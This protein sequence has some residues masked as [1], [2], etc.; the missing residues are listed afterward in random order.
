MKYLFKPIAYLLIVCLTHNSIAVFYISVGLFFFNPP[1]VFADDFLDKALQGQNL[2]QSLL[3]EFSVPNVNPGTGTITLQNGS[4]AGQT[5]EQNQLFQ[6]I[7]PGSLDSAAASYG[8]A[9]AMGTVVNDSTNNLAAGSST[10]AK[11]YQTLLGANTSIPNIYNDPI[12][13]TSDNVLSLTSPIIT[14]LFSGCEKTTNFSEK[15][16]NFHIDDLKTCKKTLK[17]ESCKVDRIIQE[18]T[19]NDKV[20]NKISSTTNDPHPNTE[21]VFIDSPSIIEMQLGVPW[22][23][24]TG[25]GGCYFW[26]YTMVLHVNDPSRLIKATI[27]SVTADGGVDITIDGTRI[28]SNGGGSCI[29]DAWALTPKKDILPY[30][31][32][33]DH[34]ITVRVS[35]DEND[36]PTVPDGGAHFTFRKKP[37]IKETFIDFPPGCRERIFNSWPPTYTPPAFTPDGSL[38]DAASTDYWKC[39]DADDSRVIETI[40]I[41]P[42]E[43]G[44]Y[45]EPILPDPPTSP[46]APICYSAETRVPGHI[47]LPCFTDM[48]GDE[49]CPEY[50][51]NL[52][53]HDTCQELQDNPQCSYI[54]EKCVDGGVSP[55]TGV[56]QQFIVTYDCGTDYEAACDQTNTGE[57]TICDAPIKCMG[58][59]CVNQAT[60]SNPDFIEAATALQTLNE[61]QKDNGCSEDSATCKLFAGQSYEC[62]MA[63]L[64]VLGSVDCCN[65]PIQG[66]WMDFIELGY[67]SW[68]AIDSSVQLY[69]MDTYGVTTGAW[70]LVTDGTVLSTPVGVLADTYNAV[71]STFTSAL[72]SVTSMLGEEIGTNLGI[73]A[74]KQQMVQ[75]LG[76]WIASTFGETAASTLLTAT[77]SGAGAAAT[78]T[79]SMAGSMLSSIVTVVGIIYA[80]YQIA[81]MVVQLVFACTEDEVQLNMLKTQGLCTKPTAIG[82]YCSADT[83]FGCVATKQVYCC[84]SSPFARIFNEQARPQ[85]GLTFGDPKTPNCEGFTPEQI[86]KLD[87]KKMDFSEWLNMLKATDHLARNAATADILYTIENRTVG[88][89]PN[90]QNEN[91]IQRLQRQTNGTNIDEQRQY[92]Q[93]NL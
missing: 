84:F 69:A 65:M 89:L 90:T 70:Q 39:T 6:E 34:T 11:A 66:S 59:E 16:C 30:F 47:V 29:H 73:E 55:V 54:S 19:G 91:A 71:T 72:D 10:H 51:Y 13:Q 52:E 92:L 2:S 9:G 78:T 76:E 7:E 87:F 15:Q 45:M 21:F 38:N 83:F 44:P 60:E 86:G 46:P 12:W 28:W 56:C 41:T 61:A 57:Q 80:I 82:D 75:W 63:D 64:S 48:N 14:D 26:S 43:Y 32:E 77:T 93:D 53:E 50:D 23:N 49:Q 33:G 20:V 68:N 58:G 8:D 88:T 22:N 74:I 5:I 81:K 36:T 17:T 31:T 37:D 25:S 67:N 27:D 42:E 62:Q 18:L 79:Y 40:T 85:L 3:N 4:V 24:D 1:T 35:S